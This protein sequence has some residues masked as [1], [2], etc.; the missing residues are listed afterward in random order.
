VAGK[1]PVASLEAFFEKVPANCSRLKIQPDGT[2]EADFFPPQI[3]A[4][5]VTVSQAPA[6]ANQQ[7]LPEP[8]LNDADL[9]LFPPAGMLQPLPVNDEEAN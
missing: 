4:A 2:I 7:P 3:T 9:A 5:P 1:R 8:P 6:T